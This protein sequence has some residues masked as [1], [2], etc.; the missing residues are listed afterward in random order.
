MGRDS[1]SERT[2]QH[3]IAQLVVERQD[4]R[5]RGAND[6]TLERNR[7]KLAKRQRE[8]SQLLID[9][10]MPKAERSAA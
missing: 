4:L 7:R 9:L 1:S 10:Y 5:A 8:L 6:A 3:E 2:L